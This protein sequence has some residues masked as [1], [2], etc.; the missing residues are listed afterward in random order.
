MPTPGDEVQIGVVRHYYKL[1]Q[2]YKFIKAGFSSHDL[3]S[4]GS[5]LAIAAGAV[6]VEKHVKLGSAEWAHFD[7]V[8]VDLINGDFKKYVND[9]R[10]A[11][12]MIGSEIKKIQPSEHHKYFIN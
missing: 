5:M 4:L 3:G 1:S 8:A 12:L 10:K 11:E 9:L 6:M 7:D 2:K